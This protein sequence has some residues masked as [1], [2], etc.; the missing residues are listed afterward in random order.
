MKYPQ[1]KSS[2]FEKNR[3]KVIK[4]LQSNSLAV[5]HSNDQMPRNGDQYFNYRQNSDLF[6]L[7][8]ID[9]EKTILTLCPN[10]PNKVMRFYVREH[11]L[12]MEKHL[13]RYLEPNEV[14]HHINGDKTDNRIENLRL[15]CNHSEH[16]NDI[17]HYSKN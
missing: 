10:H 11:R 6:Y 9:Q 14:V 3:K 7:S 16:M 1:L 12:V 4:Y 13:G 5:I 17:N 2:L 15:Y 8:G